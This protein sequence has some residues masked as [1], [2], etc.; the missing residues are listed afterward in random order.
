M[1]TFLMAVLD[2]NKALNLVCP[3]MARASVVLLANQ[4][5]IENY[6]GKTGMVSVDGEFRVVHLFSVFVD[7]IDPA[8][9]R[10]GR[11]DKVLFVG[12]PNTE[13]REDIL[14][15]LTKVRMSFKN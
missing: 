14:R 15:T 11:L 5:L 1:A 13:D 4:K 2:Q 6:Y 9:L 8:V 7:I 3:V 10:P 12:L